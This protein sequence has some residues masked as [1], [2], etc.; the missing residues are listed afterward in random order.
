VRVLTPRFA[1]SLRE[2]TWFAAEIN[3]Q[4]WRFHY[5]RQ[6]ILGRLRKLNVQSP[7][8]PRPDEGHSIAARI[9]EFTRTLRDLSTL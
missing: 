4:R 2:L 6:A 7:P 8:V 3:L 1:M 9:G 5:G